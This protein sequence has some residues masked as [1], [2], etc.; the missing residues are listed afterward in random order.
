MLRVV[1]TVAAGALGWPLA[2]LLPLPA[3]LA[4]YAFGG[5]HYPEY[6]WLVVL[7]GV[8][9]VGA[10]ELVPFALI[11]MYD[12]ARREFT[13]D[14]AGAHGPGPPDHVFC[15]RCGERAARQ[16]PFC[17]RCG[18]ASFGLQRPAPGVTITG[19]ELT[20]SS[21]APPRSQH[22]SSSSS[23]QNVADGRSG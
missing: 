9:A 22:R 10:A 21:A 15:R 13:A 1:R 19:G 23:R 11:R 8:L 16:D 17:P 14:A 18:G 20:E 12:R 7:T 3:F 6:P 2:Y 5:A 4:G